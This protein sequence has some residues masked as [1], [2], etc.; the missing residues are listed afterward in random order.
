MTSFLLLLTTAPSLK[1]ARHLAQI[2]LHQRAA[3][4]VNI[5]PKAESHYRWK[6]KIEK[7][8][9]FVL[10]IKTKR[11]AFKRAEGI[12]RQHHSYSVPEI[13]ALPIAAGSKKYLDWLRKEVR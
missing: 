7:A 3:A 6:G 1:E 10:L 2:L 13:I 8:G 5:L 9:E 11:S 12:L 4:C